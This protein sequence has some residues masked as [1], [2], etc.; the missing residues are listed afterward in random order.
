VTLL[1]I[2]ITV[3]VALAASPAAAGDREKVQFVAADQA[4][5]KRALVRLSDLGNPEGWSGGRTKAGPP[6]SFTCGSYIAKQSDLVLTGNAASKWMHAGLQIESESQVLRTEQMVSL[7]WQRT[8]THVGIVDCLRRMFASALPKSE[9]L[10]SFDALA[11]PKVAK[12]T[13]AFR[14]LIEVGTGA[15]AVRI[16]VDLVVCSAGRVELTLITTAPYSARAAV[17]TAEARLV[18]LMVARAQPGTA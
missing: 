3:V 18:Q 13:A 6:S 8:V 5:A 15:G 10:V 12:L 4:L 16:L 2:A 7:D 9:R 1:V 17:E 14:G 11:F